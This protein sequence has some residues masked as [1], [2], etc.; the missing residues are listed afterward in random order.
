MLQYAQFLLRVGE[1]VDHEG[2][3]IAQA[4]DDFLLQFGCFDLCDHF[5]HVTVLP[6]QV[7]LLQCVVFSLD[8]L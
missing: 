3:D 2:L 1:L 4:V 7:L 8:L 6:F 5:L